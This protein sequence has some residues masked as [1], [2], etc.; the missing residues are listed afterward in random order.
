M[1]I[2]VGLSRYEQNVPNFG[3][4]R[5]RGLSMFSVTR[6]R[7][8]AVISLALCAVTQSKCLAHG[9]PFT[10]HSAQCVHN[11]LPCCHHATPQEKDLNDL[12]RLRISKNSGPAHDSIIARL[13]CL[14]TASHHTEDAAVARTEAAFA[15][16]V[17][18]PVIAANRAL[19]ASLV[20]T[21]FLG[22]N[23]STIAATEAHY[24][25]MWAQDVG[26]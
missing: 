24:A 17:P 6:T 18:P 20:V 21:N 4:F 3:F 2:V 1:S 23:T 9:L 8:H 19:L 12:L 11:L 15:A 7:F 13:D 5:A 26:R 10:T 22:Q 25:E 14:R 16:T